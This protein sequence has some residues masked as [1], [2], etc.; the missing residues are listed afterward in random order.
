ML[1]V[2]K[3]VQLVELYICITSTRERKSKQEREAQIGPNHQ[4]PGARCTT[5]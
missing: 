4:Q 3:L 1:F 2:L 5:P